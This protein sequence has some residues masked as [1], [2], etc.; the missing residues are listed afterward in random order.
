MR[1]TLLF[2]WMLVAVALWAAVLGDGLTE[3]LSNNGLWGLGPSDVHQEA[4]GPAA[5]AALFLS[6]TLAW[7]AVV[8]R[9]CRPDE[10]VRLRPSGVAQR[11]CWNA[12]AV[13][14]SLGL[15][16]V[17]E[18]YEMRFGGVGVFDPRS[19]LMAHAVPGLLSYAAVALC[20]EFLLAAVLR[21]AVLVALS[22]L[23]TIGSSAAARA[24]ESTTGTIVGIVR[25][26][27]GLPIPDA[28][29][30]AVSNAGR[31]AARTDVRGSF[32]LLG[33]VAGTYVVSVSA[34]GYADASQTGIGVLPGGRAHLEFN[35]APALK[36]IGSVRARAS[37]FEVGSTSD[38][39]TVSGSRAQALAPMA[40]ASG[41]GN[42][43]SG[44]VQGAIAA[45]PGIDEDSFANAILRGGKISDA[46]FDYDSVPVPQGIVAEPGGNIAGAQLPTT[47]IGSTTVTLAGYEAQGE[48]AL[49]G[50]IDEIPATGVY[51][52]RAIATLS[53][54]FGAQ[55]QGVSLEA[56]WATPDL[57]WRYAF[58]TTLSSEYF[59]YGDGYTFY[60]AEA[61][62]YGLA[63]QSR[64]TTTLAGNVHFSVDAHDDLSMVALVGQAAYN[65]YGTPYPGETVG[66]FDG[67]STTFPGE[68]NPNAPVTYAS[69]LRGNYALAKL[70]WAHTSPHALTRVQLYR[71]QYGSSAGGPFW[72]DLSYPD[73]VISLSA[74]QGARETGLSYDV[75]DAASDRHDIKYGADYR[76]NTSFLNQVVPTADEYITSNPTLQYYLVY[77]GDTWSISRRFDLTGALRL[78][79]THV[80]PSNGNPYSQ[81]A[82]DPHIAASYRIGRQYSVR[83]TYDHNTVAP[84]PLETDRVDS[85]NL[86]PSGSP[87]PF[88]PLAPEVG[89]NQTYSF[90]GGGRTQVRVTYYASDEIN[91]IDVLP[92][93]FRSSIASG[94]SPDG[95]GVP[96]N[97]GELRAHG[98]ELYVK[99][100]GFELTANTVRAYSSSASQF[101]FNDLNAAAVA[102][103]HLFPVGYVPDL[104]ATLS[105]EIDL[106][107]RRLRVTPLLSYES[108]YP[109]GNGTMIWI[110]NPVTNKPEQVPNDN[111]YNPGYNYYFLE[112]PAQPYNA[113][114]NPYVAS[115]GTTEGS[116][117]NTLRTT[118]Q[119]LLSLHVED[120]VTSRL[121][122][123]LDWFNV[124]N[125]TTPTQLQGNPYLIGPPGYASNGVPTNN[126]ITPALPWSYGRG[127][128]VPMSYPMARTAQLSLRVRLP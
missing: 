95:V 41:L 65:Q 12:C 79:G 5:A 9:W 71:S 23:A 53:G 59:A 7:Y 91:R 90:E 110:F 21:T 105:Y 18:G 81:G 20:V 31:Y 80:A 10:C 61:G 97:A 43:L 38:T 128:Y 35:L 115:L 87:A 3:W 101:A 68:V 121:T 108:G 1:R 4:L 106:D 37:S 88:V 56:L 47:G 113:T 98:F 2:V 14:L 36:T 27:S 82:L 112:N 86:S 78:T 67:T 66:A 124:L 77:A 58:A 103:G 92:Y 8:M 45:V 100:G 57:R 25:S 94:E 116:D 120:D 48:N 76:V 123:A 33:V 44:S 62:T 64:G 69:G 60:P 85:A 40:S 32:T 11:F 93:N 46:I 13:A 75:D 96:T 6:I 70:A 19:V 34:S 104:T 109:Y 125:V 117:P 63:L 83:V 107:R 50:I 30:S 73:G 99:R 16:I 22:V 84:A 24:A 15:V 119:M 49:G 74:Q 122:I 72:D 55:Q 118:P 39:F 42:Y 126:G 28:G 51:P 127:G 29:V 17:M 54:G 111:Y 26:T 52:G 114:T 89:R 102:A